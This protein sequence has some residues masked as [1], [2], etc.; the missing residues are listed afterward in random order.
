MKTCSLL[1]VAAALIVS[2]GC[3][4]DPNVVARKYI[5]TGNRYFEAGKYKEASLMYRNALQKQP[6]SGEA[7]YRMALTALKLGDPATASASLLRALDKDLDNTPLQLSRAAR[8]DATM[9]LAEL[10]AGHEPLQDTYTWVNAQAD[11]LL[12]EDPNSFEGHR[13]KGDAYRL[14]VAVAIAR[15]KALPADAQEKAKLATAEY[16]RANQIRPRQP[17]VVVGLAGML[18]GQKNEP[19]AEKILE[20][21]VAND[22]SGDVAPPAYLL[23]MQLY[24]R[25]SREGDADRVLAAGVERLFQVGRRI[26]KPNDP[27]ADLMATLLANRYRL[28]KRNDDM[29]KLIGRIKTQAAGD[30]AGYSWAAKFYMAINDP[31]TGMRQLEEG[32]KAVPKQKVV[33]QKQMMMVYAAQRKTADALR[34][35]EDVLKANPKDNEAQTLRASLSLGKEDIAKTIQDLQAAVSQ[36]PNNW[37]AHYNLG[38]AFMMRGDLESARKEFTTALSLNRRHPGSRI[39]LAEVQAGRREFSAALATLSELS[40]AD[41]ATLPV[42]LVRSA[43]TLG[44]GKVAEAR[45]QLQ[46]TLRDFP[47]SADA[48]IQ[49]GMTVPIRQEPER[50]RSLVPQSL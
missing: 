13:L 35:A 23:L 14:G 8:A 20:D 12:K 39:G 47:N 48:M 26:G 19:E 49:Q 27:E 44:T 9:R 10:R 1:C 2:A 43:A 36:S 46:Q 45:A 16:R 7:H 38:R 50:S 41:Q 25:Q 6:K 40:P 5:D 22:K 31:D 32:M 17:A 4:R 28:L 33:L 21:Y 37:L 11:N 3:S 18:L 34:I 42:R 24:M 29:L 15:D 30:T